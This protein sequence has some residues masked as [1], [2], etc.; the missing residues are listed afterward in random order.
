M[1]STQGTIQGTTAAVFIEAQ[2]TDMSHSLAQKKRKG[3]F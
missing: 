2:N 3:F 1:G